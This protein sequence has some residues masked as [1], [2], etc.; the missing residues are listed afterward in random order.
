MSIAQ[1]CMPLKFK[2]DERAFH[3]SKTDPRYYIHVK[4]REST[5]KELK[6]A[7]KN[8]K[9]TNDYEESE[10]FVKNAIAHVEEWF[11][12]F[13]D[14]KDTE[15]ETKTVLRVLSK[16]KLVDAN[17]RKMIEESLEKLEKDQQGAERT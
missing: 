13:P 3:Y 2:I 8:F 15:D 7:V 6:K 12:L 9:K 5:N 1:I 4:E 10:E 11:T 16:S 17:L 14:M